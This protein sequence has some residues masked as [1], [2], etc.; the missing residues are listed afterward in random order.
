MLP[1]NTPVKR[2]VQQFAP[3][4]DPF[5]F[6]WGGSVQPFAMEW[7]DGSTGDSSTMSRLIGAQLMQWAPRLAMP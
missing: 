7:S 1:S 5:A 6:L 2:V 4:L 3:A